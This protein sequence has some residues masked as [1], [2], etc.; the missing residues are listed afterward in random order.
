M[1]SKGIWRDW[2]RR[3]A[4]AA[5]HREGGIDDELM[6]HFR[7]LVDE[8]LAQGM[9]ADAAWRAA[10]DRFGSLRHYSDECRRVLT[11]AHPMLQRFSTVGLVVLSLVVGW[12]LVEV[13]SLRQA[14]AMTPL[15]IAQK[16]GADATAKGE[17]ASKQNDL[18]GTVVDHKG[19]PVPDAHV[20]VIL[21]TWPNDRYRQQDFASK[22][23]KEGQFRFAKLVPADGQR[24]VH[25][26]VVKEGYALKSTYD[27]KKAG[28]KMTTDNLKLQLDDAAPVTL[29]VR[30]ARGGAAA[31][32]GVIPFRRKTA[33][34]EEHLL[35]FQ[36]A[37]PIEIT[38]DAEGRIRLGYF[39][40]GD[41]AEVYIRLPGKEWEQHPVAISEKGDVE[42]TSKDVA[43]A[44]G[45]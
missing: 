6:F 31:K 11:G 19:T 35:Y 20:L 26:A 17:A 43:G 40:R 1:S 34:G 27:L 29:V 2:R 3:A 4:P 7:S 41:Q 13:R 37:K 36:A 23:D 10:Q 12:L 16:N 28:E 8:N 44:K 9:S 38:A 25:L 42:V 22:T 18:S 15:Q 5:M 33:G 24:A 30:D 32:A 39:Q 14:A 21:K 45:R